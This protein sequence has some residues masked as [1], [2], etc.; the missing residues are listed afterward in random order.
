MKHLI[1]SSALFLSLLVGSAVRAQEGFNPQT[2]P[3]PPTQYAPSPSPSDAPSPQ[4]VPQQQYPPPPP[5]YAPQQP[6]PCPPPPPP[7]YGSPSISGTSPPPTPYPP[8]PPASHLWSRRRPPYGPPPGAVL[9]PAPVLLPPLPQSRWNVSVDALWLERTVGSS[10]LLGNASLS[11]G[12]LADAVVQRRP[13]PSLGGGRAFPSGRLAERSDGHRGDLLGLAAMVRRPLLLRRARTT[14]SW[15]IPLICTF[16]APIRRAW[17]TTWVT[18]TKARSTTPKSTSGSSSTATTPGGIGVG[19]GA[20]ATSA[21]ATTST[22][23]A[24]IPSRTT[25]KTSTIKRPTTWWS[26]RPA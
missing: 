7:P 14:A 10:V 17:T 19:S 13:V 23:T 24:R 18:P 21:S 20:F 12:H 16:R 4:Y 9:V 15:P 1:L 5:Q 8:P 22:F 11:S 26:G 6:Y 2:P 3:P 25:A